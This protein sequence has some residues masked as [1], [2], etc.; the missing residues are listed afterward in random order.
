MFCYNDYKMVN[1]RFLSCNYSPLLH[2]NSV[3]CG[4]LEQLRKD[5]TNDASNK[6]SKLIHLISS[7]EVLMLSYE[8]IKCNSSKGTVSKKDKFFNNIEL[9][10]LKSISYKLLKGNLFLHHAN[11]KKFIKSYLS[12]SVKVGCD[13]FV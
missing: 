4:K 7:M 13:L 3:R 12:R 11:K 2:S 9:Q 1:V 6:N 5:N 8:L 10:W